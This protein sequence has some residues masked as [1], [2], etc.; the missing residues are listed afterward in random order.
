MIVG[1]TCGGGVS[2]KLVQLACSISDEIEPSKIGREVE[3]SC[4]IVKPG[5][6][7]IVE[8]VPKDGEQLLRSSTTWTSVAGHAAPNIN[9]VSA[10]WHTDSYSHMINAGLQTDSPTYSPGFQ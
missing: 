5:E 4:V 2:N 7:L 8:N 1:T 6:S 3:E 9:A 10:S